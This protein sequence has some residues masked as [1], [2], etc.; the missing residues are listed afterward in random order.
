MPRG[1]R[2]VFCQTVLL[3]VILTVTQLPACNRLFEFPVNHFRRLPMSFLSR[4]LRLQFPVRKSSRKRCHFRAEAEQ[5]LGIQGK[6][7]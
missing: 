7:K 6:T 1:F 4:L 5:L 2:I 3:R